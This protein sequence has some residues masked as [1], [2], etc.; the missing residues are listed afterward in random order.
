MQDS[1]KLLRSETRRANRK[2]EGPRRDVGKRES[3]IVTS[4]HFRAQELILTREPYSGAGYNSSTLIDN[5]SADT[6]R[7]L[8]GW[9]L[10]GRNRAHLH[11]IRRRRLWQTLSQAERRPTERS[12]C[13]NCESR[14]QLGR[15]EY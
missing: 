2:T 11:G 3:A 9:L 5:R 13:Q 1:G 4:Y 6:S 15:H 10:P 14:L 8:P 7:Q 12:Q